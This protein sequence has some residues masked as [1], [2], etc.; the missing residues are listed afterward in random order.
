MSQPPGCNYQ[1]LAMREK[2]A[3]ATQQSECPG[4]N[5]RVRI[6][7]AQSGDTIN[8]AAG[9]YTM[10]GGELAIDKTLTLIGPG[11]EKQSFR[12]PLL[13]GSRRTK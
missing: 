3:K 4:C 9:V 6:A 10:T 11:S 13:R 5:L 8:I 7:S 2:T 1:L 12:Q